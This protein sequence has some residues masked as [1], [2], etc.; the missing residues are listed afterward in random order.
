MGQFVPS[1]LDDNKLIQRCLS[2]QPGAWN[3]FVDTYLNLI[4]RV[5][6]HTAHLRGLTLRPEDVEDIA[7]DVLLQI[8][9]NNYSALR[10]FQGR[11]SLAT[12]LTVICRR[13]C[14]HLLARKY[15]T[16]AIFQSMPSSVQAMEEADED[17]H[18]TD[19]LELVHDLLTTLPRNVREVVRLHYLVGL[20]YEEISS[21]MGIPVNSIGPL[22]SRARQKL[23]IKLQATEE[24][25]PTNVAS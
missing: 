19:S 13:S 18:N 4:Y 1:L 11:S 3:D 10:Q 6:H 8:V 12:Y 22:L 2:H 21:R 7:S 14:I 24:S 16:S 23:R 25:T 17:H 20:S 9:A 5:I 15:G